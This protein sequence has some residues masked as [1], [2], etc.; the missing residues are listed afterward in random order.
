MCILFHNEHKGAQHFLAFKIYQTSFSRYSRN[1]RKY[2]KEWDIYRV[3][4]AAPNWCNNKKAPHLTLF[5]VLQFFGHLSKRAWQAK[6]YISR[7]AI[8]PRIACG[9][10]AFCAIEACSLYIILPFFLRT[11]RGGC[12]CWQKRLVECFCWARTQQQQQSFSSCS[13]HHEKAPLLARGLFSMNRAVFFVCVLRNAIQ[14][15]R[16][17]LGA[18][19]LIFYKGSFVH[20][21]ERKIFKTCAISVVGRMRWITAAEFHSALQAK[22]PPGQFGL[23]VWFI[24]TWSRSSHTRKLSHQKVEIAAA[25][26]FPIKN[27]PTQLLAIGWGR[28]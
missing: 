10:N 5:F 14:T 1:P 19:K 16:V 7:V 24:S 2:T 3:G 13:I 25:D 9:R 22:I 8:G 18:S 11:H 23:A 17:K 15:A 21:L 26:L 6:L 27:S 12:L 4:S 20:Q 28:I